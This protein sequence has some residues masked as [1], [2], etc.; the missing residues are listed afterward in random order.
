MHHGAT[1]DAQHLPQP[2]KPHLKYT[3]NKQ[4][5]YPKDFGGFTFQGHITIYQDVMSFYTR[6][7]QEAGSSHIPL[8]DN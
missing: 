6:K 4:Q 2:E 1:D 7:N 3:E 8:T 5:T